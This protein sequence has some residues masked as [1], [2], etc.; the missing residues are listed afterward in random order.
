VPQC[1]EP[2][3]DQIT[4]VNSGGKVKKSSSRI[5]YNADWPQLQ[6][7]WRHPD[8]VASVRY[9]ETRTAENYGGAQAHNGLLASYND[10]FH[11]NEYLEAVNSGRIVPGDMVLMFSIDGAQLYRNK[12]SDCW[13]AIWVVF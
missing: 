9:R 5:P 4:L 11:G 7:L 6:A 1:G 2:R 3:Y 12:S 13:M 8:S 10:Y